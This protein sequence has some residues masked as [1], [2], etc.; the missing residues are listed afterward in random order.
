MTLSNVRLCAHEFAY[1]WSWMV[2]QKRE[3]PTLAH[4][5]MWLE[6]TLALYK[7]HEKTRRLKW[8]NPTR[9]GPSK[10][11]FYEKN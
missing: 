2:V 3:N 11:D 1:H 4:A 8:Q 7:V 9:N 5:R 10:S 6:T